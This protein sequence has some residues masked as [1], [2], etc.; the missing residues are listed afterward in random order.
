MPGRSTVRRRFR[1]H[2]QAVGDGRPGPVPGDDP[3][4]QPL[5]RDDPWRDELRRRSQDRRRVQLLP[6]GAD[7]ERRDRSTSCSSI[8]TKSRS[9]SSPGSGIGSLVSFVV[10][11]VVVKAFVASSPATASR[12]SRGTASSPARRLWS[13][14]RRADYSAVHRPLSRLGHIAA[15]FSARDQNHARHPFR[16]AARLDRFACALLRSRRRPSPSSF[17]PN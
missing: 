12:H 15:E 2:S 4:R 6:R 3:G 17:R 7:P 14:F 5:R 8:G 16:L 10:A 1:A 13:G 9:A 11:V